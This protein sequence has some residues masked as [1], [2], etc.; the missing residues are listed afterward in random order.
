MK[1]TV[2]IAASDGSTGIVVTVQIMTEDQ[3]TAK[4]EARAI[5]N[6]IADDIMQMLPSVPYTSF[7]L[8]KIKVT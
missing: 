8:S 5:R 2:R 6:H 4:D 1:Q 7:W 3:L